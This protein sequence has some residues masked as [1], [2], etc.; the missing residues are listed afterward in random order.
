MGKSIY[1]LKIFILSHLF[2]RLTIRQ[3]RAIER[4]T[5]YI[6]CLYGRYFLTS[7]LSTKAPCQDL[8]FYYD[9]VSFKV[10]DKVLAESALESLKRHLWYLTPELVVL[11][12]FDDNLSIDDKQLMA[13]TLISFIRPENFEIG[14]PDFKNIVT[15]L[16]AEKT[17]LSEFINAQSWLLFD[18][19]AGFLKATNTDCSFS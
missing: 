6:V 15:K 9:L 14:K 16:G 8:S 3:E 7:Q 4:M 1:I 13:V 5:M 2:A 19:A 17:T 12:M 18:K 11:G 10:I